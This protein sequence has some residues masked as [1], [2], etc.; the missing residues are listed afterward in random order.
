MSEVDKLHRLSE[1]D[2]P[3]MVSDD[4]GDYVRFDDAKA[5][6]VSL[7]SEIKTMTQA[8][9][10]LVNVG[11]SQDE[12]IKR[13]EIRLSESEAA[14]GKMGEALEKIIGDCNEAIDESDPW[15]SAIAI[16]RI[17]SEALPPPDGVKA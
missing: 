17:L 4:D 15:V 7:E 3:G 12:E 9:K 10:N 14:K 13:L 8:C 5:V 11:L 1:C 6:I 16:K 2:S